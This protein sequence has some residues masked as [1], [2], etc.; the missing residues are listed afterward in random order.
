M[1]ITVASTS[2]TPAQVNEAAEALEGD[3]LVEGAEAGTGGDRAEGRSSFEACADLPESG[4]VVVSTTD[5]PEAIEQVQADLNEDREQKRDEYLGKTRRRQAAT[6]ARLH[7]KVDNLEKQ[8][9]EREPPTPPQDPGQ[10]ELRAQQQDWERQRL[11]GEAT[12][13]YRLREAEAKY[14]DDLAKSFAAVQLPVWVVDALRAHEDGFDVGYALSKNPELCRQMVEADRRGEHQQISAALDW[15]SN[16]LRFN[17]QYNP[18]PRERQ[19]PA[20]R[21]PEPIE[22][23]RGGSARTHRSL[24]DPGVSYAEFRERRNRGEQ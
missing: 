2:D 20:H 3:Q 19:R 24:D 8:L 7:S 4:P 18:A 9:A 13:P 22:T 1:S 21:R 17:A 15:I 12:L 6:I 11:Q 14:G 5:P 16:G 10:D 23:V